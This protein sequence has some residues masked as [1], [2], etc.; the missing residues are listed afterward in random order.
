GFS[1]YSLCILLASLM[2]AS[3]LADD[4]VLI[5]SKST[6]GSAGWEYYTYDPSNESYSTISSLSGV[7]S[8]EISSSGKSAA[9]W[10]YNVGQFTIISES[11]Y[12]HVVQSEIP[13]IVISFA[14]SDIG[15]LFV[16]AIAK[17][18]SSFA[19]YVYRN[20][21][22]I[23]Q[24]SSEYYPLTCRI[25][26]DDIDGTFY[27]DFLSDPGLLTIK[28]GH[29]KVIFPDKNINSHS[30]HKGRMT[31]VS[32]GVFYEYDL[33]QNETIIERYDM[34]VANSNGSL[35]S[36]ASEME[37]SDLYLIS[38]STKQIT[39]TKFFNERG[40]FIDPELVET[41][42]NL[43][44]T[45]SFEATSTYYGHLS[46]N[47]NASIVFDDISS[48]ILVRQNGVQNAIGF[49]EVI[50]SGNYII[51]RNSDEDLF[52]VLKGPS[53]VVVYTAERELFFAGSSLDILNQKPLVFSG[54]S[55]Y[56]DRYGIYSYSNLNHVTDKSPWVEGSD[57]NGIG[58]VLS[59]SSPKREIGHLI[60]SSGFFSIDNP[61]LYRLNS[62]PRLM[63]LVSNE[64][65]FK[66]DI[67]M[68]DSPIPMSIHLPFDT[69]DIN[70]EMLTVFDGEKW[71]DMSINFILGF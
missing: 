38:Q 22:F 13:G 69:K 36:L 66:M 27:L 41:I 45:V 3:L 33:K 54:S 31:F 40:W 53:Y 49:S 63:R 37:E 4:I 42:G 43:A 19:I 6:R 35:L 17:D 16:L 64:P 57:G 9:I 7:S 34:I 1:K 46:Q 44:S 8:I 61:G 15:E 68:H 11:Q 30:I 24:F 70:L 23:E 5:Q 56:S 18:F 26:Y 28:N 20:E 62:R 71:D 48:H 60:I 52:Y 59:V 14:V 67:E 32:E 47:Q 58:E 10:N 12:N 50:D 21:T 65:L 39:S 55:F 51:Y 2:T 29:T 25:M